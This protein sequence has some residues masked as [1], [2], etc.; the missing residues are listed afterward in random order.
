M[1]LYSRFRVE[2]EIV[3]SRIYIYAEG[4]VCALVNVLPAEVPIVRARHC[5]EAALA[6]F[7]AFGDVRLNAPEGGDGHRAGRAVD[8]AT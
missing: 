6:Q 2:I 4:R 1:D 8:V 7:D 3:L 5:V